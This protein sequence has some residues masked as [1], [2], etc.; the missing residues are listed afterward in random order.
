MYPNGILPVLGEPLLQIAPHPFYTWWGAICICS[1]CIFPNRILWVIDSGP[2]PP[3]MCTFIPPHTHTLP[4]HTNAHNFSYKPT[5]MEVPEAH[6]PSSKQVLQ[7]KHTHSCL[8]STL[9]QRHTP[10]FMHNVTP[11]WHST[12]TAPCKI[13][14]QH[15]PIAGLDLP[16]RSTGRQTCVLSELAHPLHCPSQVCMPV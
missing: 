10:G 7:T 12:L 13:Y 9:D 16:T 14:L 11:L 2:V 15:T 3:N 1:V 6:I 5:Y 4:P 8:P